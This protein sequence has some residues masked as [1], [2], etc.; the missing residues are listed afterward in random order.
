MPEKFFHPASSANLAIAW[1]PAATEN[2][3]TF[4]KLGDKD[5]AMEAYRK[6]MSARGHNPP[7]AFAHSF[8]KKKL[9]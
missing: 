8:A 2:R 4:E 6:A 5:K 3:R 7:A 1:A 9:G